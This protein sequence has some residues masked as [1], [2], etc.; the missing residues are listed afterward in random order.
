[1][2]FHTGA[3]CTMS[4]RPQTAHS[5]GACHSSRPLSGFRVNETPADPGWPP[6]FLRPV[7]RTPPHSAA[8]PAVPSSSSSASS[9]SLSISFLLCRLRSRAVTVPLSGL[10]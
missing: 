10:L 6:R 3:R 8:S 7:P 2:I 1:M 9:A 5:S 4:V